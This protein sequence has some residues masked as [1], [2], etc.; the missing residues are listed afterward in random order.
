M[1]IWWCVTGPLAFLPI[2][3]AG[4]YN[5]PGTGVGSTLSDFAIS[6]YTP[7]IRALFDRVKSGQQLDNKKLGLCMISQPDTP[8]LP[9][10][11]KT[12]EEVKVIQR[13]MKNCIP[14]VLCLEGPAA[15]VD[16]TLIEMEAY[17]SIHLA[18]HASQNPT[19]PLKSGFSLHD[20]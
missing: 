11:P 9:S 16:C 18:C 12:R 6:S 17:S 10:I 19:Q 3:A 8:G 7:T 13:L 2:H 15:T 14:W 5:E 4:I 20:G 1:R